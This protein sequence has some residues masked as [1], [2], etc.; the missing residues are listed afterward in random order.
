MANKQTGD[1]VIAHHPTTVAEIRQTMAALS[2][3][4]RA[5]QNEGAAS[6]K[7]MQAG[8]PPSRPLSDHDRRVTAHIQLLMNGSTPS[9]LLVPAVSRDQQIR[10]E[11]DAIAYVGRDL[12]R[13]LDD[14]QHHEAEQW[15]LDHAT[16]WRA[17]CREIVLAGVRLASLEERARDMIAQIQS[18]WPVS[19]L[20]MGNSIGSGLSLLGVGDPLQE[21]RTGALK[22]GIVTNSELKKA[23]NV[24]T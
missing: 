1:P 22:E 24:I 12:G 13:K 16:E 17:L 18:P 21:L 14:A 23:Q 8:S 10:A 20:A 2:E 6:W 15:V 19:G 9:H 3:R 5:L 11:L 4:E 7:A